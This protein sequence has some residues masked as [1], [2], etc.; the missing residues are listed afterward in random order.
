MHF[1]RIGVNVVRVA[2]THPVNERPA[3]SR[4]VCNVAKIAISSYT[5]PLIVRAVPKESPSTQRS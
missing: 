1:E 2:F 5:F 3:L 4:A